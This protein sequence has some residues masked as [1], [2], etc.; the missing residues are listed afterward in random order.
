MTAINAAGVA[1]QQAMIRQELAVSMVRQSA[2]ADKAIANMLEQAV[3]SVPASGRGSSVDI[4][5]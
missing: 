5:A 1:V 2:N 3:D 4:S